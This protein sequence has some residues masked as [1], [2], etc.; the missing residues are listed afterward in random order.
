MSP[1]LSHPQRLIPTHPLHKAL[2]DAPCTVAALQVLQELAV[3]EG[4]GKGLACLLVP[5]QD[6]REQ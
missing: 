2:G 3:G 1:Q 5:R 6:S 4:Q